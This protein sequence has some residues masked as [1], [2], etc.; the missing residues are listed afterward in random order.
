MAVPKTKV[1]RSR[2]NMRRFSSAYKLDTVTIRLCTNCNEPS[3]PHAVCASCG[4]YD[5]KAVLPGR[6]RLPAEAAKS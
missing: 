5:G 3:R 6:K 2:R 1:T 4:H